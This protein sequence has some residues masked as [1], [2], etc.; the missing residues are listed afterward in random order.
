M[1]QLTHTAR[2]RIYREHVV[3]LAAPTLADRSALLA[4]PSTVAA[5]HDALAGL[6]VLRTLEVVP[7]PHGHGDHSSDT[8]SKECKVAFW[9]MERGKYI[10]E[11]A[12]LLQA[13]DADIILLAEM[14][15]GMARSG[16][17][18]TTEQ[19]AEKL[20]YGYAFAPEFVELGLGDA[21]ERQWFAGESNALGLHG[22][23]ILSRLPFF[24]PALIRL[25][26]AGDWFDGR[27]GERRI[28]GRIAVAI[29][30]QI[31][32][33]TIVFVSTHF[34]SHGNP[35]SRRTETAALLPAIEDYA[36]DIPVLIG[37][38]FNTNSTERDVEHW[39]DVRARLERETPG[40]LA[41]P[42]A[43]EPMFEVMSSAGFSW[44]GCNTA[45][46]TQRTRPDGTPPPPF[47]KLDWFFARGL[48]VAAAEIHPAVAPGTS[49]AISDHEV[50]VVNVRPQTVAGDDCSGSLF[51]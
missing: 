16:Q 23:A 18:N 2:A 42:I 41:D 35:Q 30:A 17:I 28:G 47:A 44:S 14:D 10:A 40:R 15:L 7:P 21:R 48:D 50:L 33:K 49:D 6:A 12:A 51:A 13:L 24:E 11:S 3:S 38:D 26:E 45:G 34:E 4:L 32:D 9:N 5:R 29:K 1:S 46:P 37:G 36:G 22:G 43:Y 27:R 31:G 25:P 39:H 20:G 19:L 8:P